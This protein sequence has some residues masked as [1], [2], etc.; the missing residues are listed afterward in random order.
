M[1]RQGQP[2]TTRSDSGDASLLKIVLSRRLSSCIACGC[3][4]MAP[5]ANTACPLVSQA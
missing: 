2:K 1:E 4:V 3:P 5:L